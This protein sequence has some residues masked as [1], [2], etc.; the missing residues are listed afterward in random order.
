L[1]HTGATQYF[2]AETAPA[3]ATIFGEDTT[4]TKLYFLQEGAVDL[5]ALPSR[6]APA[7]TA[8]TTTN[9]AAACVADAR[10]ASGGGGGRRVA[11]LTGGACF[12]QLGFWLGG[13]A[14]QPMRAVALAPCVLHSLSRH[15]MVAM[16]RDA[17][18]LCSLVS[19][20]RV[21]LF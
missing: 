2:V 6:T 9:G 4:E 19:A 21:C 5:L 13:S 10:G 8:D 20:P 17:P 15:G 3:G 7:G 16:Q 18:Q 14:Q 11:K 12:G 1:A